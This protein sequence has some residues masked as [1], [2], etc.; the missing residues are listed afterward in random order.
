MFI[1]PGLFCSAGVGRPLRRVL[2]C[3]RMLPSLSCR[4][5]SCRFRVA[6]STLRRAADMRVSALQLLM[7]CSRGLLASSVLMFYFRVIVL[8][9]SFRRPRPLSPLRRC[10]GV[11]VR[12]AASPRI[13][14]R[15]L[16]IPPDLCPFP[17]FVRAPLPLPP[18]GSPSCRRRGAVMARANFQYRAVR[19]PGGAASVE[20]Y[21]SELR[22]R[23]A[24]PQPRLDP[25]AQKRRDKL[26]PGL[27]YTAKSECGPCIR[28]EA[29]ARVA[30]LPLHR[31]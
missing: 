1:P 25:V 17:S 2:P 3:L 10:R 19:P 27:P 9:S 4:V 8:L 24:M 23:D 26:H 31:G 7:R 20:N 16:N 30:P 14:P 13:R 28:L 11:E 18:C 5:G 6:L 15:K 12:V 22:A 21:T 29:W